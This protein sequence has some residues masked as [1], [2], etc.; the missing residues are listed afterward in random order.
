[1]FT[2]QMSSNY[3][4]N[5]TENHNGYDSDYSTTS[6]INVNSLYSSDSSDSSTLSTLSDSSDSTNYF[7]RKKWSQSKS[8]PKS[9][10]KT[11]IINTYTDTDI[12]IEFESYDNEIYANSNGYTSNLTKDTPFIE[13][14]IDKRIHFCQ[15]GASSHIAAFVPVSFNHRY[16][17]IHNGK[18]KGHN[19]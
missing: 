15:L 2:E 4:N 18:W 10:I 16:C 17:L 8:K 1:M 5:L 7:G 3:I 13:Y 12:D 9:K 6:N 14:L 19:R 11:K